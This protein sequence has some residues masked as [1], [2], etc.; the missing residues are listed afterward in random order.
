MK[1]LRYVSVRVGKGMVRYPLSSGVKVS[2][3][4]VPSLE[5]S[6]RATSLGITVRPVVASIAMPM[7][8]A[9]WRI[10]NIDNLR[11]VT[12][13]AVTAWQLLLLVTMRKYS[14]ALSAGIWSFI[15]RYLYGL[16][17]TLNVLVFTLVRFIK[18]LRL[19]LSGVSPA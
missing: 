1:R 7:K 6:M 11:L 12:E 9:S 19:Q 2:M 3:R 15:L 18:L 14:P 5:V 8:C 16:S 17:W 10:L 13:R 4:R